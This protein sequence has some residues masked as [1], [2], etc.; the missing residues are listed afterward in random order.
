MKKTNIAIF[1]ISTVVS[2]TAVI[3]G[4]ITVIRE[5]NISANTTNNLMKGNITNKNLPRGYRNNNPLNIRIGKSRWKGKVSPNTDGVFEQFESM[6]Y[7][8]RAAL[9]LIQNYISSGN[10]TIRKI[11]SKWAPPTENPTSSYISNV[12]SRIGINPDDIVN[13]NNKEQMTNIVYAMAISEN[14]YAPSWTD[15][16]A[17]WDLL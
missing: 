17:G 14:G 11:I 5:R 16:N 3:A 8:F 4:I 1:V 13:G 10:N 9:K 2:L 7:G 15:V 12:C 6:G